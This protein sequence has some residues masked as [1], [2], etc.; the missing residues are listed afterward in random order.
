MVSARVCA[1]ACAPGRP[2][3]CATLSA[4]P[5]ASS[6]CAWHSTM[7]CANGSSAAAAA[8]RWAQRCARAGWVV[9]VLETVSVC[10]C[11]CV[12]VCVCVGGGGKA[13]ATVV[14]HV[15]ACWHLCAAH[16]AVAPCGSQGI[17]DDSLAGFR[18]SVGHALAAGGSDGPGWGDGARSS[19]SSSSSSSSGGAA[20]AGRALARSRGASSNGSSAGACRLTGGGDEARPRTASASPCGRARVSAS[21]RCGVL[22]ACACVCG[23]GVN[24]LQ[25]CKLHTLSDR[26]RPGTG[27]RA[28]SS[29]A[30]L[31]S[32]YGGGGG[33]GGGASRRS[34]AGP[35]QRG[36][37]QVLSLDGQAAAADTGADGPGGA[38]GGSACAREEGEE[39]AT[40]SGSSAYAGAAG[41]PAVTM[42]ARG[43]VRGRG[44]LQ[45][46][47]HRLRAHTGRLALADA[48]HACCSTS[49]VC[50]RA[51]STRAP[52]WTPAAQPWTW[53]R[54]RQWA[55]RQAPAQ[56]QRPRWLLLLLLHQSRAGAARPRPLRCWSSG[57]HRCVLLLPACVCCAHTPQ[58]AASARG[59][60]CS[61]PSRQ[62]C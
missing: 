40:G 34:A 32:A 20:A 60:W 52:A 47:S 14:V 37:A 5:R 9:P 17:C 50:V 23:A 8:A 49:C 13:C 59:L 62:H 12:V 41:K 31:A 33:G 28:S 54:V 43:G 6:A 11:A 45:L 27:S 4:S 16:P 19:S 61:P 46:H 29:A 25:A 21:S 44:R 10:V 36:P 18:Q 2:G 39:D 58:A 3:C 35:G 7:S 15:C 56:Q 30:Q 22:A 53:H 42:G 38:A 57:R 26:R 48:C 51:Q 1:R 24:V 55:S